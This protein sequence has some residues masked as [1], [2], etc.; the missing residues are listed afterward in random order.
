MDACENL[1]ATVSPSV[2]EV[3]RVLGLMTSN[4]LGVMYGPVCYR[5]LE[6]E[7]TEAL[8]LN[9][10]DFD[11]KMVLSQQAINNIEWWIHSLLT[12]FNKIDHGPP[13][14]TMT[15]DAFFIGWGCCLNTVSTWG[16]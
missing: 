15:T 11:G 10:G 6:M 16:N 5:Y 13:Q 2:R 3:A 1:L 12:A 7:K 8:K 14:C 9:K 4:F